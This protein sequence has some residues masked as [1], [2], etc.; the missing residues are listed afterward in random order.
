M[1]LADVLVLFV[2]GL[3]GIA[4]LEFLASSWNERTP[5]LQLPAAIDRLTAARG[6]GADRVLRDRPSVAPASAG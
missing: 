3:T 1:A 6:H 2:A 4:S 5:V